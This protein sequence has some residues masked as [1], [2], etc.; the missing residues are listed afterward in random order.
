MWAS[1]V[2]QRCLKKCKSH[3]SKVQSTVKKV[4]ESVGES[5]TTFEIKRICFHDVLTGRISE[6][7]RYKSLEKGPTNRAWV[8]G[9]EMTAE[10]AASIDRP[11]W[12]VCTR[13]E[14]SR[15]ASC[16][17]GVVSAPGERE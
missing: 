5:I 8:G 10:E 11:A 6:H 9:Q 4:E 17:L 13:H 15:R 12:E 1:L 3:N 16:H 14:A 2:L 7:R